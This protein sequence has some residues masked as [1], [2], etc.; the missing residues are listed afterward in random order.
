VIAVLH[1]ACA[2]FDSLARYPVPLAQRQVQSPDERTTEVRVLHGTRPHGVR[3][4]MVAR[5]S[6]NLVARVRFPPHT[7]AVPGASQARPL[8]PKSSGEDARLSTAIGEFDPRRDRSRGGMCQG[9]EL[10]LQCGCGRFDSGPLHDLPHGRHGDRGAARSPGMREGSV[11]PRVTVRRRCSGVVQRQGPGLWHQRSRFES[12]HLNHAPVAKW[13]GTRLQSAERGFDSRPVLG[14]P[15]PRAAP[16]TS[17]LRTSEAWFNSTSG[18]PASQCR[19]SSRR[20]RKVCR[21][22]R[23]QDIGL[24][25]FQPPRLHARARR[26]AG[27]LL[28]GPDG[29]RDPTRAP[30]PAR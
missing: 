5:E 6:V 30:D 15:R 26:A 20:R 8:V 2:G 11:R 16:C 17:T 14:P 22:F 13:Q 12:S 23:I 19:R 3:S 7:P 21:L 28:N 18:Y 9:G 10:H 1:T 24:V 4:V 25:R 29:V 27:R